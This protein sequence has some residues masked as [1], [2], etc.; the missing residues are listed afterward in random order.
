MVK[1]KRSKDIEKLINEVIDIREQYPLLPL[2][3]NLAIVLK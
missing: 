1:R 3:E 2:E